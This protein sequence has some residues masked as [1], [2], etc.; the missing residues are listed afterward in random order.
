MWKGRPAA[1]LIRSIA[2]FGAL[3]CA[4]PLSSGAQERPAAVEPDPDGLVAEPEIIERVA[5]FAGRNLSRGEHRNGVYV[6]FMNMAPGAGWIAGGPGYRRWSG[7]DR[8]LLDASAAI[9]WRGYR[10][11]Q[12][13]V[14]L[15]NVLRRLT[16]GSQVR[17]QDFTQIN[18]FGE[19][20]ASLESN[21]SEYRLRSTN[22]VGYA[23][24]RPL[25]WLAVDGRLGWL[26]P[27]T[28]APAGPFR[29]DRPYAGDVFPADPV[30]VVTEQPAFAHGEAAITAD[31]RDFPGRPGRGGILRAAAARYSDR[32]AGAFSFTRYEAE[33]AH[34]LPVAGSR[35]VVAVHGWLVASDTGDG[36]SVPFY[37]QPNLGGHNS[38][39]SYSDYRFHDRNMLVL[40]AE[41]RVAMMRHVDAA[42]FVDAGNVAAR[43][44]D[45]NVDRK[46]Y[47]AGLRLHARRQTIARLDLARG[48]EGW[49]VLFRLTDPLSLS[50]LSRRTAPLPFVP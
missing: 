37:L 18:T 41:A 28:Q 34:F 29:S 7:N 8:L 26:K 17:W 44:A 50:R 49:R 47:G 10:T 13:R 5:L 15:P 38:L 27:S 46:S 31:T 32:D 16:V 3:S 22:L 24:A 42:V 30:F 23:T 45:L 36:Q 48:G 9:S 2:L 6:D 20:P 43:V 40:N 12:A 1:P 14:E 4:L 39:R 33:A 35:V 11:G 19:G 25:R 21:R